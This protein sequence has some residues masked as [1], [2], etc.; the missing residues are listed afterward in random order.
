MASL[1]RHFGEKQQ[2]QQQ[3]QKSTFDSQKPGTAPY[4]PWLPELFS[5]LHSVQPP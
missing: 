2:A 1:R 5:G 3:Q 4:L